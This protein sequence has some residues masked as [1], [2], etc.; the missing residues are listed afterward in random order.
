MFGNC[1][2]LDRRTTA[3][4]LWSPRAQS[5][6]P[7]LIIGQL[8]LGNPPSV[9]SIRAL[10]LAVDGAVSGLWTISSGACGLMDGQIYHYWLEV[11]DSRS[12]GN[13]LLAFRY[14]THLHVPSTGE[15]FQRTRW[16]TLNLH[17]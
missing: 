3:F 16:T 6:P 5:Q 11:D 10:D 14:P 12:S 1:D 4:V 8:Q 17:R 13:P 15:F 2:I 9:Q 7:K